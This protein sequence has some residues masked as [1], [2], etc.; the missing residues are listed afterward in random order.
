MIQQ[1]KKVFIVY[2]QLIIKEKLVKNVRIKFNSIQL[3][4]KKPT[5]R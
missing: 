3:K 5:L 1:I 2:V 4:K